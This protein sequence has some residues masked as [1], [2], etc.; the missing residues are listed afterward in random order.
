MSHA[1]LR[2]KGEQAPERPGQAP[3]L[4]VPAHR[5]VAGGVAGVASAA[6]PGLPASGRSGGFASCGV[7]EDGR[8]RRLRRRRAMDRVLSR[9]PVDIEV[10]A[11]P[12]RAARKGTV[13]GVRRRR[14]KPGRQTLT[15]ESVEGDG[16][17]LVTKLWGAGGMANLWKTESP[18][19]WGKLRAS[20]SSSSSVA[21][22]LI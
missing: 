2:A 14:A 3:R 12:C 8:R 17:R 13:T 7:R 9:D 5:G 10:P 1:W 19:R 4:S 6:S 22:L 21:S 18:R 15:Q 20:S 11:S 16:Q